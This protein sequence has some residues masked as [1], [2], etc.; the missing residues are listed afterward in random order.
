[1]RDLDVFYSTGC[2]QNDDTKTINFNELN[3]V[4]GKFFEKMIRMH[5]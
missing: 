4:L 2:I 1:M 3:K 5:C